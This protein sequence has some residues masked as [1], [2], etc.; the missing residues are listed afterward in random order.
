[1]DK[2]ISMP[3]TIMTYLTHVKPSQSNH[4]PPKVTTKDINGSTIKNNLNRED[5]LEKYNREDK[6]NKIIEML[7]T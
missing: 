6:T 2:C 7:I 3:D 5:Q 4:K 1:M